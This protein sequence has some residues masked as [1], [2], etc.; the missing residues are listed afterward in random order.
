MIIIYNYI[1]GLYKV[2]AELYISWV[3][4]VI[5]GLHYYDL[6]KYSV[7][8][9]IMINTVNIFCRLDKSGSR[10]NWYDRD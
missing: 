2:I 8:N 5:P 10:R 7:N 9:N 4:K 1:I 3:F 6:A